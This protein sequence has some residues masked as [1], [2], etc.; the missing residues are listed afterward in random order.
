M[1]HE[2]PKRGGFK[3]GAGLGIEIGGHGVS[4]ARG[5]VAAI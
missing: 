3:L 2:A 4:P 5:C 1:L